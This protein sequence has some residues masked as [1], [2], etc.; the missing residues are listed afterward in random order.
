MASLAGSLLVATPDLRD[1]NFSRTVVLVL[2]HADEGALGVVLNRP[3]D[4]PV[5]EVLP[6]WS[7]VTAEP[8][9]VFFG[10]PVSLDSVVG[11]GRFEA[12]EVGTGG[13]GMA[14]GVGDSGP[15]DDLAH[16]GDRLHRIVGRVATV[17]LHRT[18]GDLGAPRFVRLFAGSAGWGPGQLEDEIE[19]G[20]W[21]VVAAAE[22]DA[23]TRHPDQLWASVLRRQPGRL[24][25]FANA[26][27]DPSLN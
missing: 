15:G 4:T 25:W 2:A 20:S 12:D 6:D 9:V 11:L 26:A 16:R 7:G 10:G 5:S 23:A 27:G 22:D 17:D 8:G 19:E 3:S 1:P 14:G 24:A 18:P 13:A 21:F